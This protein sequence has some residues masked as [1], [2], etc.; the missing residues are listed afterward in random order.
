MSRGAAGRDLVRRRPRWTPATRSPGTPLE[1]I[2]VKGKAD[3]SRSFALAGS[4]ARDLLAEKS[5][6]NCRWS[7]GAAELRALDERLDAA[8]RRGQVVGI[9]AEA[10]MGKSRLVAEFVRFARRARPARCVRGMPGVR[11]HDPLPSRGGRSG[12]SLLGS[13]MVDEAAQARDLDGALRSI[14]PGSSPRA[15][16]LGDGRG[17]DD[18]GQRADRGARSEAAQ[19]VAR[20]AARRRCL[21]R[22]GRRSRWSSCSRTATGSTSCRGICWR[23]SFAPAPRSRCCSCSPT[24]RRHRVGGT[25]GSNASRNSTSSTGATRSGRDAAR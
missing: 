8:R 6:T 18:P 2:T 4:L 23:C 3:P 24:A 21:R 12:A 20:R 7:A 22:A 16:L 13:T 14:D 25:S 1:P 11:H 19:G 9:A 15:P 10:G 5:A 17:L